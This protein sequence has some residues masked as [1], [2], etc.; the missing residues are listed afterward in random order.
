M[1]LKDILIKEKGYNKPAETLVKGIAS[2]FRALQMTRD[3]KGLKKY[4]IIPFILNLALLSTIIYFSYIF[5]YPEILNIL[6]QGDIW[7]LEIIRWLISP[8]IFLILAFI[9]VFIYS[10]T[11]SI[12]TAPFN[13][14]LS[15]K[16]EALMTMTTFKEKNTLSK[17]FSDI[18]RTV[19]NILKLLI[20]LTLVNIIIFLL[21]FVPVAGSI[22]YS[23]LSFMSVLFFWGF[24]FI[25]IPLDK[26]EFLFRDKLK[27]AWE[28]KFMTMGLG[29]G[30]SIVSLIPI[31]GFLGLNLGTIGATM[32]FIENIQ[33]RLQREIRENRGEEFLI[34]GHTY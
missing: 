34:T 3:Q 21:N 1:K 26:R 13:D 14:P 28:Y 19:K 15:S 10:I 4:F 33:P 22:I 16:V 23:I 5:I 29:L 6:P 18:V 7:Y 12:I 11:G 24:S 8:I 30:F 9:I 31:L 25:E 20:L 2:F 32:L 17:L 27:I